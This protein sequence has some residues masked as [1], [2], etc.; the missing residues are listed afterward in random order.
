MGIHRWQIPLTKAVKRR[1]GNYG[2]RRYVTILHS[3]EAIVILWWHDDVI[4]WKPFPRHWPF[5]RGI[6]RSPVNSPHKG[7]WCEAL[8]F[9]LICA[10]INDWVNTREAD[11]L[12]RH[13]ALYD[14]TV[15][16]TADKSRQSASLPKIT[17]GPGRWNF[18]NGRYYADDTLKR[19]FMVGTH[20]FQLEFHW[21]KFLWVQLTLMHN[22]A[23]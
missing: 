14:V 17:R 15:M 12:R 23:R 3:H 13:R 8:M 22:W 5:V 4:K 18:M 19:I 9:P 11:G 20:E 1:V 7:Q 16:A 6:H 10:W 2:F 21:N